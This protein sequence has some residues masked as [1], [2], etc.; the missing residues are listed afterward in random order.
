MALL[1]GSGGQSAV[2]GTYAVP[3]IPIAFPDAPAPFP[4]SSYQAVLF[5]STTPMGTWSVSGYYAYES[6]GRL[7]LTGEVFPW[8]TMPQSASFYEDGC[9]GVGVTSSCPVRSQSRM[10]DL[11]WAALDSISLGAGGDTVWS[12]FDNDGPDGI[13]NSGDDD[14]EVDLVAFLQ[15]KLDGACGG[16]GIWAHRFTVAGWT[17]GRSYQTRTPRRGTG[18]QPI[19]GQYLTV[20]SYHLESAVGGKTACTPSEIMPIGTMAHETGHAFGLPD[21]YDTSPL[22]ASA[23]IGDWGLMGSGNYSQPWSPASFDAWS[24]VQLGWVAV[25]T[26]GNGAHR[27]AGPIQRSDT[28][29]LVPSDVA[30]VSLL[31]ENR[32]QEGPDSAMMNPTLTRPKGPGLLIWMIDQDRISQG[33]AANQVNVGQR[34]GISLMQADGLDQLRSLTP[35]MQNRG[36]AGDP[37]PG[38]KDHHDFGLA[39]I[40]ATVSWDGR[41]LDLRVDS[42]ADMGDGRIA[43]RVTRRAP[44]VVASRTPG[45]TITV[46]GF[47]SALF[48]EVFAEGD[49]FT[50]DAPSPQRSFDGRSA[51]RFT[52][53]SDGGSAARTIMARVG[54][55]D[56]LQATFD[57]THRVRVTIAG[58]GSVGSDAPGVVATGAFLEAGS[59]VRLS[60]TPGE[61]ATFV[62]WRGDT[63][64]AAPELHLA[65]GHPWDVTA[66]FAPKVTIDAAVA[67]AALLGGPSLPPE[68]RSYLD[69][70][71]NRNGAYDVGDL[72]AWVQLT[73]Q[74]LPP[75][76]TK[77]GR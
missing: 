49:L 73:G 4:S 59:T 18:G 60:A 11:L 68:A 57:G 65:V 69:A 25:D 26:L 34:Q 62:G 44:T 2:S 75:V 5:G 32:Q 47:P 39:T 63:S 71:G 72:L 58:A 51:F 19:P 31:L 36:D 29:Y 14:G 30:G 3:V 7:S 77:R 33:M 10:V 67:T 22:V 24:L 61:G 23:G 6:R 55:P 20:N 53:W 48:R 9:N 13:P 17:G 12:R 41:P 27:V 70:V 1:N 42:I 21:L 76:L 35:G 38:S 66:I 28:V 15:A 56:T 43:F 74:S 52:D 40:P 54:P 64:A 37:W 50:L 16:S 45:A 46:N 8:V